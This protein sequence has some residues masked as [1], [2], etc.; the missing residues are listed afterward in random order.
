M[1]VLK[2]RL[3]GAEKDIAVAALWERG[4]LGVLETELPGNV[5]ELEAWF[6]GGFDASEFGGEA[7]WAEAPGA[8]D[9]RAAW[10]PAAVGERLWLVPDWIGAEP[11]E[12]RLSV[13][14]H[15]G[16]ASGSGYQPATRLALEALERWMRPGD[17][18]LDVG[19][20]TGILLAAARALGAGK[21]YGCEIGR[22]EAAIGA[23]NLAG[24]GVAAEIWVGSPRSA[25]AEAFDVVVANLNG[26]TVH[27]L[28]RE[29]GRVLKPGGR[30]I[31][32]GFTERWAGRLEAA[33]GWE[34]A[35]AFAEGNWRALVLIAS[36][37][38][39]TDSTSRR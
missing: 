28:R 36:P 34:R 16:M 33:F 3:G 19:T 8:V 5:W 2:L 20:G 13:C 37:K 26:A 35:G 25:R 7:F 21:L 12:G 27:E 31:L 29:F 15:P 9:W 4:T 24:D 23:A 32:S 30:L 39:A 10:V 6:E 11:P 18:V 38:S 14:V 17:A 22:E 1:R